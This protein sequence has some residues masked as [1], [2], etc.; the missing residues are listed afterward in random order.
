SGSML[1]RI[2]IAYLN[3]A[4]PSEVAKQIDNW[5]ISFSKTLSRFVTH[6]PRSTNLAEPDTRQNLEVGTLSAR[7]DVVWI[8]DLPHGTT[9]YMDV[10]EGYENAKNEVSF[11]PLTRMSWITVLQNITITSTSTEE[12]INQGLLPQAL[13]SFHLLAY[14]LEHLNRKLA[15]VDD[16]N[17]ERIRNVSRN[18]AQSI[19]RK[20]LYNI[21]DLPTESNT[22]SSDSALFD[23]LQ[24]IGDFEK[25]TFNFP[26]RNDHFDKP[27]GLTAILDSS[28][29]RSRSVR[30]NNDDQ[31]WNTDGSAILAYLKSNGQPVVLVPGL[32]GRYWMYDPTRKTKTRVTA[33]NA[34][35]LQA[36]AWVFY[37]PLPAQKVK[38]FDLLQIAFHH[39]RGNTIRLILAGIPRGLLRIIPALAIGIT[40]SIV[41]DGGGEQTLYT[42]SLAVIAFGLVAALL[43]ILQ[44]K[45]LMNIQDRANAQ[46]ESAFW[47]RILRLPTHVLNFFPTSEIALSA[48]N[49]QHFRN[50]EQLPF[51]ENLLSV[52]FMLPMLIYIFFIDLYLG[53]IAFIVCGI[54]LIL[55]IFAGSLKIEPQ[56]KV[57]NA[58]RSVSSRLFQI[59]DSIVK[60]RIERAEGSAYAIWASDYRTL[61]RAELNLGV[62]ERHT[63]AFNTFLPFLAGAIL[64]FV[65]AI[66]NSYNPPVGDFLMVHIVCLTFLSAT[67]R[68]GESI[69]SL[70]LGV[71]AFGQLKPL[72]DSETEVPEGK[73]PLEHLNGDVLFDRVSF[74][75]DPDGP[76]IL[77]DITIHARPGEFVAIAGESG[78]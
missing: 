63:R 28:S 15:L 26:Q 24:I 4:S 31:W 11:V 60:L 66:D 32:F 20:K 50:G 9:L 57:L 35:L 65:V 37:R 41:S 3:Q 6:I 61:K 59:I 71:K 36:D 12:V 64:Y 16:T 27:V 68:L 53:L 47:D 49:F 48:M 23:A 42:V 13:S 5:I 74:R 56:G 75:Y 54:S 14:N 18:T 8:S 29:I 1:R 17:L 62:L 73:E 44:N 2:P 70:A 69:G 76:L 10:L 34:S 7:N 30:L 19:A 77:D 38:S 55:T 78:A 21:Y 25:I 46:I 52:I 51:I 39:C 72:L 45:S 67:T 22:S 33:Q 43:H 40:L 58:A